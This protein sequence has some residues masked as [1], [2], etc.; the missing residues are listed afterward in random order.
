MRVYLLAGIVAG[1]VSL[2]APAAFAAE[3]CIFGIC[4]SFGNPP[5]HASG[6]THPAPAPMLAAGIPAFAALG[7]GA[8][9]A[10]WLRNRRRKQG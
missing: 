4:I 6:P 5:S 2:I 10:G 7:G 8:G 9:I 1:V 3:I